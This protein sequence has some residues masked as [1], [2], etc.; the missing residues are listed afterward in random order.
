[1]V[2][3][4]VNT[5]QIMTVASM[6]EW[7]ELRGSEV[8]KSSRYGDSVDIFDTKR[9]LF[10]KAYEYLCSQKRTQSKWS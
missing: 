3:K 6:T 10:G 7:R 5:V 9:C 2:N 4:V 1:M 8:P